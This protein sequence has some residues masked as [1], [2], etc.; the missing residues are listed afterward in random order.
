LGEIEMNQRDFMGERESPT[1][2]KE[3]QML[4]LNMCGR[5]ERERKMGVTLHVTKSLINFIS[6]LIKL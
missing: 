4:L 1:G 3:S 5:R 2:E 6:L